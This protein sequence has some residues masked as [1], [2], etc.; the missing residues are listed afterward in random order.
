[1]PRVPVYERTEVYRG[2]SNAT[3][4][5]SDRAATADAFGVQTA[6]A[7]QGLGN[8]VEKFGEQQRANT[9]KLQADANDSY[10]KDMFVGSATEMAD[11]TNRF[12]SLEGV[13]KVNGYKPYQE[14]IWKIREKWLAQAPNP[15][16][17]KIFDQDFSR[18]A[19]FALADGAR[20]S[21]VANKQYNR[22]SNEDVIKFSQQDAATNASDDALF[23]ENIKK[24][25]Q[26]V[27]DQYG[28]TKSDGTPNTDGEGLSEVSLNQKIRVEV[29]KAWVNRLDTLSDTDPLRAQ[30]LYMNNK[31]QIN[32]DVW[33]KIEHKIN[34]SRT[35]HETYRV[36]DSIVNGTAGPVKVNAAK[37]DEFW[38]NPNDPNFTKDKLVT[39]ES[40]GK[41]I[42]VHKEAAK[43]FQGFLNELEARGYKIK[44][45]GGYGNRNIA[46]T[47][48]P[49]QHKYGNAIDINQF[50]NPVTHNGIPITNMPTDV[51][52]LAA[53]YNLS[54]GANWKGMKTDSMHF[55]WSGKSS[56]PLTRDSGP[57]WLRN[58]TD[59]ARAISKQWA[60][61]NPEYEQMLVARVTQRYNAS[62]AQRQ[63]EDQ[64]NSFTLNDALLADSNLNMDRV[65]NNP[66]LMEA[67]NSLP[68]HLQEVFK[69]NMRKR[70]LDP[71]ATEES[72]A[73][74][75]EL[76]GLHTR[77]VSGDE[78]ARKQFLETKT[79]SEPIPLAQK[80][81]INTMQ[82][83][84]FKGIGAEQNVT[85]GLR[86]VNDL[87]KA[88][89]IVPH[90]NDKNMVRRY[91]EIVGRFAVEVEDFETQNKKKAGPEDF[92]R[93]AV[94]ILKDRN[95]GSWNP[96]AR[97]NYEFEIDPTEKARLIRGF[98]KGT[99]RPPTPK[100]LEQYRRDVQSRLPGATEAEKK[101]FYGE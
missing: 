25:D 75:D 79:L 32:P 15:A 54:W 77:A 67:F 34:Q 84:L 45:L 28:A 33:G 60:P 88:I 6:R 35:N 20:N 55:E 19:V 76:R 69:E 71:R 1:M 2:D 65:V 38:G 98:E 86:Q 3:P 14:E 59:Q 46:F 12:N 24:I 48:I 50:E 89:G 49:S 64:Q 42:Q 70:N 61:N 36:A 10:A 51:S 31:G 56:P 80:R 39:I 81:K 95:A 30:M 58:A 27:R 100:E 94:K 8:E 62:H 101:E 21:A 82:Q 18:R 52:E 47:N 13:N 4:Y 57:E 9:L 92:N 66:K 44:D 83:E 37:P 53:K 85:V 29:T 99:G 91:N 11:V 72:E 26:S 16:V 23:A 93:I 90:S 78:D 97:K 7:M 68:S 41:K 87:V 5:Y 63:K 74:M 43:D 40:Q 22:Q 17:R 96:F 73:R